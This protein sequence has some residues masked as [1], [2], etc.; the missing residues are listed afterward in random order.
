MANLPSYS[1]EFYSQRAVSILTRRI[2]FSALVASTVSLLAALLVS[3]LAAGGFGIVETIMVVA[4]VIKVVWVV[5]FFW[6]AVLGFVLLHGAG[7]PI[8]LVN[9][10]VRCARDDQPILRRIAIAMTVRNED[11]ISVITHLKVMKTGLDATGFGEHFH[12]FLLSD[13][14]IPQVIEAEERAFESWRREAAGGRIVYRRRDSNVGFKGGNVREF[15]E[16]WGRNYEL[17]VL[18]DADSLMSADAVLRLVRIMQANPRLGI[19][20]SLIV[21]ILSPSLFSR[22]FEFG[23]RHGMRCSMVGAVWWQGDRGQYRGHNAAIRIAPFAERCRL[24]GSVNEHVAEGTARCHDQL[25][26]A[27]L[28]S[29][30]FEVREL[31]EEGGSYEGLPPTLLDFMA[32][33]NRWIQGNFENMRF[34][35]LPGLKLMDRYHLAAVA[36]RFLGWPAIILFV[37][38]AAIKAASWSPD[39]PFPAT[40]S[41]LALYLLYFI[42][43]FAPKA[44][45][46]IDALMTGPSRYG[47]VE[48]LLLG[49]MVDVI[50]TVLFMPITMVTATLFM[51]GMAFRRPLPWDTQQRG[52]YRVSWSAAARNLWPHTALGLALLGFLAVTAASAILWFLPFLMGL[53][54]AVPFAVVSSSPG[55]S[56][57]AVRAKF[58]AIPEEIEV[59]SEIGQLV[60]T[61]ERKQ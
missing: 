12:Y 41:A 5:L 54:L 27:F 28:H 32:R 34:L 53:I 35:H 58:C 15:C 16:R 17:M 48:R 14:S 6:Q 24:A 4:F 10:P 55:S 43:Y 39:V 31:P 21:G 47:G 45:G 11:P 44:L 60:E 13:S 36:H 51:I 50:F 23:H 7:D 59:P 38:L 61:L 1:T 29:A 8:G 37:A 42:M 25:E 57:W 18:L 52:G 46:I 26:G 56:E 33:Y 9:P 49:G 19:L 3:I 22:V 40:S 2:V 30:G 20:Q